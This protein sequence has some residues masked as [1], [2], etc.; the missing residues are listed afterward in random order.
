MGKCTD[1]FY[2]PGLNSRSRGVWAPGP[3]A[4]GLGLASSR[5]VI[6]LSRSIRVSVTISRLCGSSLN[7]IACAL[8]IASAL[9][10]VVVPSLC[11]RSAVELDRDAASDHVDPR[12]PDPRAYP[13]AA[14]GRSST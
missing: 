14:G 12:P 7:S 4:V 6:F 10:P 11:V 13:L 8:Q 5:E 1:V 9:Q 2:Q 3:H